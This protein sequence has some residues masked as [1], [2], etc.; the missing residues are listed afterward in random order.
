[1]NKYTLYNIAAICLL[2]SVSCN[3]RKIYNHYEHTS[4]TGWE[5]HERLEFNIPPVQHSGS[6]ALDIGLRIN[7]LYPYMQLALVVEHT[8]YPSNK[9][10][11]EKLNCKLIDER[12]KR[13]GNGTNLVQY[14]YHLN[15]LNLNAGDSLHIVIRHDMR[16][17]ILP[18]IS[19]IGICVSED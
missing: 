14:N 1:M 12:G 3:S 10:T 19:D 11:T 4:V 9:T 13:Q 18:G 5:K 16:R 6:Y 7:G 15:D 8:V 17:E 2:I